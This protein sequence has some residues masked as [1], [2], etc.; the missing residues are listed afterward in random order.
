MGLTYGALM[1]YYVCVILCVE[2]ILVRCDMY[3]PDNVY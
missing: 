2:T 1:F 3:V